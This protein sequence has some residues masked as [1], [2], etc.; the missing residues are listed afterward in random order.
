MQIYKN[1]EKVQIVQISSILLRY[2]CHTVAY[3]ELDF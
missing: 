3:F 2:N 1:T